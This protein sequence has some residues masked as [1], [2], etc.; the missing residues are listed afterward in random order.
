MRAGLFGKQRPEEAFCG[1]LTHGVGPLFAR[2]SLLDQKM[3]VQ[4]SECSARVTGKD[5]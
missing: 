3:H 4:I 5:D 2:R 1:W